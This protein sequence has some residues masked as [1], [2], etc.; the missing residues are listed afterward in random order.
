MNQK[1]IIKF[2]KDN[3]DLINQKRWEEVYKKKFPEG[4]TETILNCGVNPLEQ[5]LDYIPKNFLYNCK[6][7][8]EFTIPNNVTS[9]SY[10]AFSNCDSLT[11]ITIGNR[12]IS[13]G[14]YAFYE[15]KSLTSI[16][17]PDSVES[18]GVDAFECCYSLASVTIGDNVTSIGSDA[19]KSCNSLT[20]I[21]IPASVTS[22]GGSAF[23]FC[24]SLTSVNY[25]GT[26]DEWVNIDFGDSYSNP[27]LYTRDLYINNALVNKANI[28]SAIEIKD[29]AFH[30]CTSLESVTIGDSVTSIG[31][32][33]FSSCSNL[34]SM[35][36]P[37][38]VTNIGDYV[39]LD[40]KSLA[41]ITYLGTK[42]EA[43]K[44]GIGNRSKKRWR[45]R[46]A[47]KKIICNDGIIE[48]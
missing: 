32:W 12:V 38:T 21:E 3:Q 41:K 1:E 34:I 5:G 26:I 33:A 18:I 46:S 42:K 15:C 30:N 37:N 16:V 23:A 17:I 2:L 39:F 11:N 43:M 27:T 36:I 28:T 14:A 40:C 8:K 13:I 25:T 29:E 31:D 7:I 4:F 47:I 44:L 22:I 10:S 24:T 48:L 45:E 6:N 9:I 35:I 20:S 19:F